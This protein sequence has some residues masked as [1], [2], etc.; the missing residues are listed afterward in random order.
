MTVSEILA[1]IKEENTRILGSKLVGIYVHGSYVLGCFTW[2]KSDLDYMVVVNAPLTQSE[3][4][5]L[6][7]HILSLD[8]YA[9]PKGLE[10]SVVLDSVC[11]PFIYPTPFQLHFSNAHKARASAD[12]AEYC[13]HMNGDDP[14]LA[15]HFTIIRHAGQVLCGAPIADVFAD[16]P[17]ANYIDS[18][19]YDIGSAKEDITGDPV[20]FILNLCRVA[21]YVEDDLVLSKAQGGQWGLEKLPDIYDP[22]LHRAL[23]AYA[24]RTAFCAGDMNLPAFADMMLA[25]IKKGLD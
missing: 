14:D 7:T 13:A 18:I 1:S 22:M 23:D 5:A 25:R 6:I 2:E 12:L 20:Y 10:M 3:K 16:V 4:E 15:A 17:K 24:A 19:L 21:A 8:P 11:S 9:P